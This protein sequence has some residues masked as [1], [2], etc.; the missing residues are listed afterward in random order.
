MLSEKSI[1]VVL[2]ATLIAI[3]CCLGFA[4]PIENHVAI[5][6]G[7]PD[8]SPAMESKDNISISGVCVDVARMALKDAG[9][10][11]MESRYE[12]QWDDVLEK[13]KEGKIDGVVGLYYTRERKEHTVYSIPYAKD[14]I[15]LFFKVG[16]GF[17]YS[18]KEDLIGKKGIATSGDSYGQEMDDFIAKNNLNM[19]IVDTPKQGFDLLKEEKADYF[20]YSSLA[21]RKTIDELK[22]SGFEES[23]VVSYQ[24]FYIGISKKSPYAK[25][26]PL[27]NSS[28]EKFIQSNGIIKL[29]SS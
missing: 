12:G 26:M 14:R 29:E 5:F 15:S 9:N 6:S 19:T 22:L 8:W 21:G 17:S 10:I 16:K 20:I 2:A 28:L 7:H 1:L 11:E 18:Q 23:G 24:L 13:L 3:V 27:I 4:L 25:Y